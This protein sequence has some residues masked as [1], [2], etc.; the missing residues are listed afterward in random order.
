[1]KGVISDPNFSFIYLYGFSDEGL[2][3][4]LTKYLKSG[5]TVIDIGAHIGYETLLAAKIVGTGGKVL[6]FEPTP[7]T[8]NLLYKNTNKF[9]NITINNIAIWS[10]STVLKFFDYGVFDSGLNSFFKPRVSKAISN[11]LKGRSI[12]VSAMSLDDYINT[13]KIKPDFV[14]IDAESA[15]YDILIGMRR[16][17][18]SFKPIIVLEIGDLPSQVGKTQKCIKFL[19]DLGYKV[20][21]YN[22]GIIQEHK[23]R[24]NYLGVYDNLLFLPK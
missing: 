2:T 17:V 8:Y 13:Y 10:Q 23:L 11:T 3:Q 16:K 4:I 21:E 7:S 12:N 15:E 20:L 14:K 9:S 6:A 1:M 5:M 22:Q 24:N 18:M 19:K